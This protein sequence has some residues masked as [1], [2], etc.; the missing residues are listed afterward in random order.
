MDLFRPVTVVCP[1]CGSAIVFSEEEDG[2]DVCGSENME[3]S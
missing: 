2:C 3:L 1:K